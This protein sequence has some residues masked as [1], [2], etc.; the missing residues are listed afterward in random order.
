MVDAA[1]LIAEAL[2]ASGMTRAQLARTLHISRGEVTA[3]LRGERNITVRKLAATLHALGAD[4]RLSVAP[5]RPRVI[6]QSRWETTA[7]PVAAR[8]WQSSPADVHIAVPDSGERID[9]AV[10]EDWATAAAR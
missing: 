1:E 7:V 3:R 2:E 9:K 4:L 8:S 6:A 5:R 10:L